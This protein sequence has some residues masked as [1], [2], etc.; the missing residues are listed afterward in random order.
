MDRSDVAE[1]RQ[2]ECGAVAMERTEAELEAVRLGLAIEGGGELRAAHGARLR[3]IEPR[4]VVSRWAEDCWEV[5]PFGSV[6]TLV[7]VLDTLVRTGV[8]VVC[9]EEVADGKVP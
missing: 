1:L 8:L 9:V 6:G 7:E 2:A 4:F 3:K 5:S